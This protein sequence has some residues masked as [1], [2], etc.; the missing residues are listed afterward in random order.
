[1]TDFILSPAA[2]ADVDGIWDYTAAQWSEDQAERYLRSIRDA[3][4]DLA[5]GKRRGRAVDVREG[6][7]RTIVG[8]HVLYFK[9]TDTGLIVVVRV[10]HQR[11]DVE[12]HLP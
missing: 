12:A 8:S 9:T 10:L 5:A 2:Q 3:C 7:Q 6:Y 11:M 4:R 1:M